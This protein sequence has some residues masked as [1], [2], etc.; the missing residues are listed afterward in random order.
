M[1]AFSLAVA[2][3]LGAALMNIPAALDILMSLYRV[4]Y[5]EIS[6]L[7]SVLLWT[8]GLM[9]IPGGILSDR[10]GVRPVMGIALALVVLSNLFP[11]L[12]TNFYFALINRALCGIG[13]GTGFA[14]NM[15]LVAL[16]VSPQKGGIFQAYMA[17][18]I[19]LGS[20]AGYLLLPPLMETTWFF[21][22]VLPASFS[23]FLLLFTPFLNVTP[24]QGVSDRFWSIKQ[25]ARLPRGWVL[26]CLHAVSWGSIVALGSWMPSFVAD[27]GD[28]PS[29]TSFGWTGGMV[30]FISAVGRISGGVALGK[31]SAQHITVGS[32][33]M[34]CLSYL[35][36]S[37]GPPVGLVVILG[38][39]AAWFASFNFGAIFQLASEVIS[40]H[41]IGTLFGFINFVANLGAFFF[42]FLFGWLKDETG[43][44]AW[45]FGILGLFCASSFCLGRLSIYER[46]PKGS[47]V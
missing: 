3:N 10:F 33:L 37:F 6:I 29:A 40:A 42:T 12:S 13:T 1:V 2:L 34:I 26:G 25:I 41:S 4:S 19:S 14:V 17:G 24:P 38:G 5:V 16:S 23:F 44:F 47:K 39:I 9:L 31:W 21:V 22:Y 28:A 15:K 36:L 46:G 27:A 30:L 35:V 45:A 18:C 7:V 8:H 43:S 20:I 32:I 11:L